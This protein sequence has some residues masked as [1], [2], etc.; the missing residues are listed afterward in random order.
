MLYGV[1]IKN[2]CGKVFEERILF[3]DKKDKALQF[4]REI[5][6]LDDIAYKEDYKKKVQSI[7][8]K[9]SSL[10]IQDTGDCS[11]ELINQY[12]INVEYFGE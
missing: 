5:R 1:K 10:F 12:P 6:F 9:Y 3:F 2:K 8:S 4:E 11:I 7:Y